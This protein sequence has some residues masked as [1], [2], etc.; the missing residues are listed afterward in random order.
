[1]VGAVGGGWTCLGGGP[2]EGPPCRPPGVRP[3][4]GRFS[5]ASPLTRDHRSGLYPRL[6]SDGV[7]HTLVA[8]SLCEAVF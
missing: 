3:R 8:V 1:M 7:T 4:P 6:T 2:A 5:K